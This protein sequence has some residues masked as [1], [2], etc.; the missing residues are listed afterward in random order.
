MR[1]G[2]DLGGTKIEGIAIG[3]AGDVRLRKRI[4]APRDD[5]AETLAAVAGLVDEIERD[6]GDRG[7]VGVGMPGTISPA[8]G[9]VKNA[10]STW[11]NGQRLADDLPSRLGRPVRF[12]ND[13]N[14]F[15][16]SEAVDGA[17]A[18]AS[19][20]FGVIIGTGTGGGVVID[21]RVLRG[22]HG[23]AAEIGHFQV[24]PDGPMC[25][26]GE[27]GH[28]EA[29]ASGTAL[30]ALGRAAALAGRAPSV[31]ARVGGDVDAVRGTHVG[32]AARAGAPDAIELLHAYAAQVAV[33]LVALV[34]IFDSELVV[35]SGGLVELGAL[36]L[37]PLRAS[38]AGR[39][40]GAA[41][42]PVVPVEPADL[43][44][45]AG[46]VGAAVRARTAG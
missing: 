32:D 5:Y 35:V 15:A 19:P 25:A 24:D 1:I 33:G 18:G 38:F 20:V 30:G 42:R 31:L 22:A 37:D 29:V 36:L 14:C 27:R 43:G 21:G 3:D 7:T 13:A 9:L 10:N 45:D 34:N 6:L 39:L 11:L 16:L 28:W 44:A 8:T 46:V 12:A 17:A 26:C 2:I 40:E 23:F 41:Y 4:V